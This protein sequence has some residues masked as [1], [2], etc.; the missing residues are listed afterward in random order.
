M[1]SLYYNR[2]I[3]LKGNAGGGT[4]ALEQKG[5]RIKIGVNVKGVNGGG[6]LKLLLFQKP[7]SFIAL[8]VSKEQDTLNLSAGQIDGDMKEFLG[9]AVCKENKEWEFLLKGETKAFDWALARQA[10][11][12]KLKKRETQEESGQPRGDIGEIT[13]P[14]NARGAIEVDAEGVK[15]EEGAKNEEPKAAKEAGKAEEEAGDETQK[16]KD[17]AGKT[18]SDM[19]QG[20]KEKPQ[21]SE[22]QEPDK[23][24]G[25][26][27]QEEYEIFIKKWPQSK[28]RRVYYP[29]AAERYYILG[30]IYERETLKA[31]CYAVPGCPVGNI[32]RG[33]TYIEENGRGYWLIFQNPYDGKMMDSARLM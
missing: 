6:R 30:E 23:A 16:Q 32:G 5:N 14:Q 27:Q 26:P 2:Y 17:T 20:T 28:W 24:S 11:E 31:R 7:Q 29:G 3:V 19:M 21:L 10:V 8:P 1:A 25:H 12:L 15:N 18:E 22:E 33:E 9:F 4:L 13:T